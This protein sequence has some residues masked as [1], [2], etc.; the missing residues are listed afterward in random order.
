L[1][2]A[3]FDINLGKTRK[4]VVHLVPQAEKHSEYAG[5]RTVALICAFV[6]SQDVEQEVT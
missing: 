1:G 5:W 2:K 4:Q 6:L 3:C